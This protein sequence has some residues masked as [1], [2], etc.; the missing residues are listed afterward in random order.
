MVVQNPKQGNASFKS[1]MEKSWD[2]VLGRDNPGAGE[3]D[4]EHYKTIA[5]KE[6]QGGAANN[7]VLFTRQNYQMRNPRLVEKPRIAENEERT[8]ANVG[9]GSYLDKQEKGLNVVK[10]P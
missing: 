2:I 4:T 9:P 3:Y 5:N 1:G 10:K 7:F 8:P 6:F